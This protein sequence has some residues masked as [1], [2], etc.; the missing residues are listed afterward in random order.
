MFNFKRFVSAVMAMLML[1]LCFVV[2]SADDADNAVAMEQTR[3]SSV[4]GNYNGMSYS[5]SSYGASSS[6]LKCRGEY[7]VEI[8]MKLRFR[9][10][11]CYLT[12]NNVYAN[13]GTIK[14]KIYGPYTGASLSKSYT[15]SQWATAVG[16]QNVPSDSL[17][18]I[19][20]YEL[21]FNNVDVADIIDI[22]VTF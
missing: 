2:V 3:T 1:V 9:S 12:V 20:D 10:Q 7:E 4:S 19:G 5:F 8:S 14:T 18:R 6:L 21:L 22:Y 16:L 17:F 13:F 15:V 11:L